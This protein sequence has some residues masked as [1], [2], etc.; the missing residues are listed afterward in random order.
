LTSSRGE[1]DK[2]WDV[3]FS[4]VDRASGEV[5]PPPGDRGRCLET[6]SQGHGVYVR[7]AVGVDPWAHLKLQV[8][9]V[10]MLHFL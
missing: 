5:S 1:A 2:L 6:A 7:V 4:R 10:E 3:D 9:R 8:D